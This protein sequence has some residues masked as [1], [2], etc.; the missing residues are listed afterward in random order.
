MSRGRAV[1]KRL[2]GATFCV[3]WTVETGDPK[4]HY[5]PT[6]RQGFDADFDKLLWPLVHYG[7]AK[8]NDSIATSK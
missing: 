2:N 3:V 1:Q 8:Q 6:A 4:Q 5:F 7:G